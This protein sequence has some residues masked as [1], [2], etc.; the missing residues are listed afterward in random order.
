MKKE[1]M[2]ACLIGQQR[3]NGIGMK[4]TDNLKPQQLQKSQAE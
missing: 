2:P 3:E 1:E 4:R